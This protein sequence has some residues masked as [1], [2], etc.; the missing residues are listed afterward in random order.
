[1]CGR[2]T[3]Y[4]H[5]DDLATLFEVSTYPLEARYN[6]APTQDVPVIRGRQDGS[7]EMIAMRWGLL[8]RWADPATFRANLFNARSESAAEKPSFR[9]SMRSGRCLLPAAGF[10]EWQTREGNVK[11]PYHFVRTDGKTMAMAGLWATNSKGERPLETCTILTTSANEE[12]STV[13]HRMPVILEQRDWDRWLDPGEQ[14]PQ[15]LE[16]LLS[17][18]RAGTIQGYPVGRAV[19]NARLDEPH[20]VQPLEG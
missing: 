7:R 20:L 2:Y 4:G 6:I 10:Y 14:D 11:Q 15:R 5:E 13:H 8:P 12:M 3:L 17:P 18:A 1:M 19:G 9:E 16:D